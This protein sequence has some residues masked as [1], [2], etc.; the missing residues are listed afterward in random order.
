M[1]PATV[2]IDIGTSA[3]KVA[4]VSLDGV[5]LAEASR[6]YPT[7]TPHPGWVEQSPD[8]WW[9]A[10]CEALREVAGAGDFELVG[11]GLSGQLNGV[12]LLDQDDNVLGDAIIWL[13]TRAAAEAEEM[14]QRFAEILRSQ[15][16]TDLSAIAVLAKLTWLARHDAGRLERTRHV[17]LVKDYLLWR[18][19]G[20]IAT[21]PSDAASTGMMD[22]CTLEWIPELCAGAG[23][24]PA[25][26]PPIVPSMAVAGRVTASTAEATG[27]PVELPVVP[28]GGD[29]AALAV[30]C[31]V[32]EPGVLGVTLGTAGHVVLAVDAAAPFE[33]S[34]GLWRVA[35]AD[36]TRAIWLG[37]VMS[38]GLSLAWLHRT[39]R[40]G[41]PDFTFEDMTTLSETAPAGARG[42][43][44]VPFLEGSATPHGEPRARGAFVGLSSSSSAA[45]MIQA[46]MEGVAFN[47]LQCIEL[48]EARGATI[49]E[50]RMAEGGARVD[51]WCQVMADVLQRPIVRLGHLN[52]SSLGAALMAQVG[53]TKRSLSELSAGLT[54]SGNR[55][56]PNASLRSI[57]SEAYHRFQV[58]A[59]S[60]I[61]RIRAI[62][63]DQPLQPAERPADREKVQSMD[64]TRLEKSDRYSD[65]VIYNGVVY[66]SGAVGRNS[67]DTESQTREALTEIDRVLALAGT[68]KSRL[69]SASVWL[70]D[71]ADYDAMNRA[72][73]D[74]VDKQNAP[75]RATGQVPLARE[76]YR[77][78]ITVTAAL[79]VRP[80]AAG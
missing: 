15:A 72:W 45:E 44:F 7:R 4:V 3:V 31:G 33:S 36:P 62:Q 26:L 56:T 42:V 17:L 40:A 13:D 64:I 34:A 55:F 71:I 10:T 66:L 80:Q 76:K 22:V 37:L 14:N 68:D 50:V 73:D 54:A 27:L 75:A 41:A 19:T 32:A 60:E 23:F 29:V 2:G 52:A 47:V 6:P 35:H 79:P 24:D 74:W 30:G 58:S 61:A 12:V 65:A 39:L 43:T 20:T 5:V 28:G 48:F 21:D 38:G 25:I 67:A 51:R 11:A 1:R 70:A 77:V 8:D 16:A 18:L 63:H 69:L 59:D 53:V 57:Y 49:T 78:E 46:V 9:L